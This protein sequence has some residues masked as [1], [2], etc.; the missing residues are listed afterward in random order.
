M[1]HGLNVEG[2][3]DEVK[4][5]EEPQ[6]HLVI[7]NITN[8]DSPI[9]HGVGSLLLLVAG[10]LGRRAYFVRREAADAAD[11]GAGGGLTHQR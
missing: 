7:F 10:L 4:R 1:L 3:K 9:H 11:A 6:H 5:V 8:G 2:P